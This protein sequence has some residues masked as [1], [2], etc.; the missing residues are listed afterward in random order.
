MDA[1]NR[2]PIVDADGHVLEPADL[3]TSYIDPK[4]RDRA[5]RIDVDD[6]G[7]ENLMIDNKSFES[8]RGMLGSIG[9]IDL[10]NK[11][12]AMIP[13]RLTYE[14]GCSL[15]G[16]DP[17]ER[18]KISDD[19]EI[20][21]AILYPTISIFWEGIV[22]DPKLATAYTRAYNRWI[23][24][25]C[26]YD[27]KRLVPIAHISLL[28]PEGAVE[29]VIRCKKAG[30]AGIYL[31]PDMPSR[32]GRFFNDPVYDRFW[33]TVQEAQMP[34][35]L[36]VVVREDPYYKVWMD[37]ENPVGLFMY[38]F[39]AMD[40]IAGF[41]LLLSNGIFDKYPK[42]RCA[43]LESGAGWIAYWLDRMDSKYGNGKM[44]PD[45]IATKPSELF[46]KHC[47]VSI[48]PDENSTRSVIKDMGAQY[49][50]WASDYPHIDG[51]LG[52]VADM[53]KMLAPLPEADQRMVLG[54]NVMKF[55][56]LTY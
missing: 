38:A 26:S 51:A 33:E 5:I 19:E 44:V 12:R 55:Y 45:D 17:A 48:D 41:T 21:I 43:V 1:L 50:M 49:F 32:A 15:G 14:D 16:Y 40:V 37:P 47:L 10:R 2:S 46:R 8:L 34:I 53:K 23:E 25:F 42:I 11:Y 24:E 28:D 13:G 7:L 35:A 30:M 27:R 3:W 54:E 39:L 18:L 20:D 56:N 9:G 31:S 36:H 29:E 52:A 4:F 6:D 22:T